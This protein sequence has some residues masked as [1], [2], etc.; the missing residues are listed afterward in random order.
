M[1][2][3]DLKG[4]KLNDRQWEDGGNQRNKVVEYIQ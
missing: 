4:K 3:N 2:K 1:R